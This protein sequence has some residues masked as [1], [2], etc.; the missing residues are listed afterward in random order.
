[1]LA[2]RQLK[3]YVSWVQTVVKQVGLLS[4]AGVDS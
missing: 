2:V 4:A 3:C 1:M